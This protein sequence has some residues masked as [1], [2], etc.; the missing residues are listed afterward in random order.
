MN[1]WNVAL[2]LGLATSGSL[3]TGLAAQAQNST[4]PDVQQN[5]WAYQAVQSLADKGLVK[6]YPNGQ[7][8]GN[9]TMTRYEFATVIDRLL[10]TVQDMSK[11]NTTAEPAAPAVTQDDLNK[12]Q[13]LTDEF[14][15]ELTGIQTD[16]KTAQDNIEALRQ[17]VLDTKDMAQS[18]QKTAS[19]AYSSNP[20]AKFTIGGYIQTRFVRADSSD[21]SRFPNGKAASNAAFN[22]N[23]A[24][25]GA[26]SSFL[27]RRSRLRITGQVTD[28][29]KY[30]IQLDAGGATTPGSQAVTVREGNFSYTPGDGSSAYPT[31]TVGMLANPFGYEL[32]LSS[33][34]ILSPERPLA[35]AETGNG[36]FAGQ[37]YDRGIQL[38]YGKGQ[39]KFSATAFNGTGLASNDTTRQIDQIYRASYQTPNKQFG[40]GVSYDNG[41]IKSYP[42]M[43][44]KLTGFDAQY[45]SPSGPF[46]LGEYV[47][48]T[49]ESRSYFANATD[50]SPTTTVAPG[51][52]VDGYYVQGGY[53]ANQSGNH[54]FTVAVSFDTFN[55]SK[56]GMVDSGS[57]YKDENVGYGVLYNMDKATRLRIWYTKPNSVAHAPL[58]VGIPHIGLLTTELQVKF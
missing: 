32:P 44:K 39:L 10:Q 31:I 7:F 56:S 49:F 28:N 41:E 30:A 18:A 55:R 5:H 1:R 40:V 17:D 47:D 53:T 43:H 29:T 6:G 2:A 54:P 21:L 19:A 12:I 22:G 8:L 48:G 4:F 57:S 37:D 46:I 51:N 50:T 38:Y 45:I 3:V 9:R 36:L 35:F 58:A 34:A 26:G 42:G 15:T 14:K 25:G 13:V 16:V 33:S 20:K 23:Y 27:L 11:A 24:Q 52:K